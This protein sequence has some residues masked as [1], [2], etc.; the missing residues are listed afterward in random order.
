MLSQGTYSEHEMGPVGVVSTEPRAAQ[1]TSTA[2]NA[3]A[4]SLLRLLVGAAGLAVAAAA[5]SSR[6]ATAATTG[7]STSCMVLTTGLLD[8]ANRCNS[9]EPSV[10]CVRPGTTRSVKRA[11][12]IFCA[13]WKESVSCLDYLPSRSVIVIVRSDFS[14][15]P[16]A[17]CCYHSNQY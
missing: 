7:I 5:F 3:E 1:P 13:S 10:S 8:L 2:T 11:P 12:E 6:L 17:C 15:H 14:M 16:S 9:R 4:M